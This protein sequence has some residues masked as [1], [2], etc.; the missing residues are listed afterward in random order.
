MEK[1]ICSDKYGCGKEKQISAFYFRKDTQKYADICVSCQSLN[2]LDYARKHKRQVSE[3]QKRFYRKNKDK[4]SAY[5]K[6]HYQKNK[7]EILKSNKAYKIKNR[8]KTLRDQK[9]YS[10]VHK[11]QTRSR[12]RTRRA[13]KKE[14]N[15]RFSHNEEKI[16]RNIFKH[17]CFNCGHKDKLCIDHNYPLSK[18]FPLTLKNAV[19]LCD[20]CNKS[21]SNKYPEEFYTKKKFKKLMK[22]IKNI[23]VK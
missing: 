6:A 1:K 22:I 10:R 2:K 8:E 18:G 12:C 4:I 14:I 7:K 19:L 11:E 23:K 5:H 17:K 3:T 9:E 15:E 20:S 13:K 16:T 21:K